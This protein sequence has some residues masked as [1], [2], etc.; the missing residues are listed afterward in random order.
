[1][2]EAKKIPLEHGQHSDHNLRAAYLHVLA[3]ALTSV[4]AIVAL[5]AGRTFGWVWMDPLMGIVG[6]VVISRWAI[7]L[8]RETGR[9]L[10]DGS[11]DQELVERIRA[12]LESD[13]D[14]RISDLHVW[15]IGSQAASA[16]VSLVTH[17]PRPVEHYRGLLGSLPELKHVT[18]EVNE[19]TEPPCLPVEPNALKAA[20]ESPAV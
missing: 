14:T 10:L 12:A 11:G 8:L 5:L 19:C 18:I 16:I 6:G 7:G 13:A 15:M 3:D 17:Y 2:E 4:L 9:I 20:G 1:V